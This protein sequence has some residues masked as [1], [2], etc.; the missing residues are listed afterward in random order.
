MIIELWL[1]C[2][3]AKMRDEYSQKK[4]I[5]CIFSFYLRTLK[6]IHAILWLRLQFQFNACTLS[7][8]PPGNQ[9]HSVITTHV[10]NITVT[11]KFRAHTP[12]I[13]RQRH[14]SPVFPYRLRGTFHLIKFSVPLEKQ[15]L[16]GDNKNTKLVIFAR[17]VHG[18][19]GKLCD[20]R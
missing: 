5:L 6:Y 13:S 1:I 11:S 15:R 3:S 16:R 10:R 8:I 17:R 12:N 4:C 7:Y 14:V 20:C 2:R 19:V 9:S 18:L